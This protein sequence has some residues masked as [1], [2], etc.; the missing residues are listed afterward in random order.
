MLSYIKAIL[1]ALVGGASAVL[2]LSATVN[3]SFLNKLC[4]GSAGEAHYYSGMVMFGA[5]AAILLMYYRQIYD[6][7]FSGS[8]KFKRK[9]EYGVHIPMFAGKDFLIGCAP[10][11]LLFFPIGK[12]VFLFNISDLILDGRIAIV[13]GVALIASGAVYFIAVAKSLK[14]K[15]YRKFNPISMAAVGAVQMLCSVLP[16]ASRTGLT[17]STSALFRHRKNK[18]VA[19]SY[20]IAVPALICGGFL[21][22]ILGSATDAVVPVAALVLTFV[23]SVV[24]ALFGILVFSAMAG[25]KKSRVFS[26]VNIAL[27]VIALISGIVR[28]FIK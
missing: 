3:I 17:F 23:I 19:F 6:V 13:E 5:S 28:L 14:N 25:E 10:L 16:G 12:G 24:A 7:L 8:E 18:S 22:I 21:N 1:L 15:K 20:I 9:P 11:L 27:G 2:P 4:G 26:Y